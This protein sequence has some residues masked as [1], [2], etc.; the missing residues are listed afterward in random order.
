MVVGKDTFVVGAAI[1]AL[2]S[3]VMV[4]DTTTATVDITIF[5]GSAR[6]TPNTIASL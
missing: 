2:R 4:G 3:V 5:G 1:M 6:R